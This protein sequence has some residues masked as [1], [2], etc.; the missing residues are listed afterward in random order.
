MILENTLD[1]DHLG[2]DE[3]EELEDQTEEDSDEPWDAKSRGQPAVSQPLRFRWDEQMSDHGEP[4]DHCG[5]ADEPLHKHIAASLDLKGH[6]DDEK[7]LARDEPAPYWTAWHPDLCA[8]GA[9]LTHSITL[10]G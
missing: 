9:L 5:Y 8:L 6:S 1:E 10:W 3:E 2:L 7:G 4:Q